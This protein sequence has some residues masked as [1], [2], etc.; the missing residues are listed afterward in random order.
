MKMKN[1]E[2]DVVLQMFSSAD[3]DRRRFRF[4][5]LDRGPFA[6]VA[7]CFPLYVLSDESPSYNLKLGKEILQFFF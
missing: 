3:T 6:R 7:C 1:R 2:F 5:C 4:V